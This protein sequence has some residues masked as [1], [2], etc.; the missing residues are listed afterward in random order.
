MRAKGA[1][2]QKCRGNEVMVRNVWWVHFLA[3]YFRKQLPLATLS[4]PRRKS[5]LPSGSTVEEPGI[6]RW[7]NP[8]ATAVV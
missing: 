8:V 6:S 1:Y 5:L 7:R 4:I 3:C 2:A